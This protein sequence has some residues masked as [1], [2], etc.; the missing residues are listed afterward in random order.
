MI[1]YLLLSLVLLAGC[2]QKEYRYEATDPN[3][4]VISS[5][6]IKTN[7]LASD[8]SAD[9]I[10]LRLPNGVTIKVTKFLKLDDSIRLKFNPVLNV[11]ELVTSE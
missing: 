11:Y 3:G 2:S 9:L 4:L 5:C 6:H 7:S 1:K 10:D 8:S